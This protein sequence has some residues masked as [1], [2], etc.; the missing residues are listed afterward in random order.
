MNLRQLVFSVSV[1]ASALFA[2]SVAT[3]QDF[4]T[5]KGNN[6][7]TGKRNDP[8]P[9]VA[10]PGEYFYGGKGLLTWFQPN[11]TTGRVVNTVVDDNGYRRYGN[12][13]ITNS[14]ATTF[15]SGWLLP[16]ILQE[17]T[18]SFLFNSSAA[19]SAY[20]YTL[21]VP[22][23]L[24]N[25]TV[26][27]SGTL[28]TF[29]WSIKPPT[30]NTGL[31]QVSVWLPQGPTR[32]GTGDVFQTRYYVYKIESAGGQVDYDVVDTT[33]GGGGWVRLGNGG[34]TSDKLFPYDGTNPIKVTLYNT[35]P[36]DSLGNLL[37]PDTTRAV[38]ADAARAVNEQG[39]YL[40]QP[41][42]GTVGA[43]T[44]VFAP[45]TVRS[46]A[47]V[48]GAFQTVETGRLTAYKY[49]DG[50][51]IWSLQTAGSDAGTTLDNQSADVVAQYPFVSTTTN[52]KYFGYDYF[53]AAITNDA[54][55][56]SVVNYQPA[57]EDGDYD[58]YAYLPGDGGGENYGTAVRYTIYEGAT[59]TNLTINQSTGTGW[60]R[61]GTRKFHHSN[62]VGSELIV[63][64]SNYSA[65]AGDAGKLSYADAIYFAGTNSGAIKSTP[66]FTKAYIKPDAVSAPVEKEV[67]IVATAD[68]RLVCADA[69]GRGDGTTQIY[70]TYP[71]TPDPTNSTW[72]D[73][74]QVNGEDGAGGIAEM[75][76]GFDTT[77]A[78]VQRFTISGNPT[79]Y[80]YIGSNNGRVY[81]VDMT[82]RGDFDSVAR[83]PGTTKRVWSYTSDYPVQPAQTGT[84]GAIRGSVAYFETTD[85]PTLYVPS[86]T[87]RLYALDALGNP[88]NKTT[89]VRW[90]YPAF[91]A[92]PLAPISCTPAIE[93]G[94][95]YFGTQAANGASKFLA[96]D[97][98]TGT[99]TWS[100]NGADSY[101]GGPAT[102]RASYLG[103]VNP[104]S[105][106]IA[107]SSGRVESRN[108]AT[109]ALTWATTELP[110]GTI[111]P[112]TFTMMSLYDASGVY[113][114]SAQPAIMVAQKSGAMT[115]LFA[116]VSTTNRFGARRAWE[117]TA[118]GGMASG[119]SQWSTGS[120]AF[121]Y[122][123]A[124]DQN[125]F[126]YAFG[127]TS[128]GGGFG[129]PPGDQTAVEN[130]TQFDGV[131][132]DI[133]VKLVNKTT[134]DA[135]K[136]GSL[137]Y[138]ALDTTPAV[139]AGFEWGQTLYAVCYRFKGLDNSSPTP[140]HPN[141]GFQVSVGGQAL[142]RI[143][144]EGQTFASTDSSVPLDA[145]TSDRLDG[146]AAFAIIIQGAG[147][148]A[149]P[150]GSGSLRIDLQAVLTS[151]SSAQTIAQDPAKSTIVF[152]V[153][154]PLALVMT[155][156]A[157]SIGFNTNAT[158]AE[159]VV[160]GSPNIGGVDY[161]RLART[162]G[163]IGHGKTGD[164]T[165]QV[166]DRSLMTL[167]LGPGR[168]LPNIR[169]QRRDLGWQGGSAAVYK[170]LPG[171]A[172]Q[173]EDLPVNIPNNSLDY[174]D[175]KRNGVR[176][177]KDI[178]GN[179]EN[180]LFNGVTLNPPTGV[181]PATPTTRTLVETPFT[182]Q[183]DVPRY[184]PSNLSVW[185]DAFGN[186]LAGG[187]LGNMIVFYDTNGSGVID[188][189]SVTAYRSFN[190]A[191]QVS[192][193]E[194]FSLKTPIVD[195]GSL[196]SGTG[197]APANP[198]SDTS[199]GFNPWT[200]LYMNLF[201][202]FTV[203]NEGNVNLLRL[204][205]AKGFRVS[206]GSTARTYP[207]AIRS[208]ANDS[209][210]WLDGLFHL[211]SDIDSRMYTAP[212][213]PGFAQVIL[214]KPRVG[215]RSGTQL[216]A[217]PRRRANGNLGVSSS[218][219][220]A[221]GPAPSA[222]KVAITVP[223]GFPVGTYVV[224]L[225]VVE[226]GSGLESDTIDYTGTPNDL[227]QP[228]TLQEGISTNTFRLKF[229][230]TETRLTNTHSSGAATMIEEL[231][232]TPN[233]AYT[234]V[235][236]NPTGARDGSG[237]MAVVYASD[238]DNRDLGLPAPAVLDPTKPASSL[239]VVSL[240]GS[241][242]S[243]ATGFN[244][245]RDLN[246]LLPQPTKWFQTVSGP[247]PAQ[248][249]LN[250]LFSIGSGESLISSAFR[251]PSLP[252][253]GM[254][255]SLTGAAKETV[256]MAFV[257]DAVKS[258]S[259]GN[260][261]VSRIMVAPLSMTSASGAVSIGTPVALPFDE[262]RKGRI[263]VLQLDTKALIVYSELVGNA[264][265]IS[266]T[267]FDGT[268]FT[269][270]VKL[271]WIKG[272]ES[273]TSPSLSY[274]RDP[275][276]GSACF[277]SFSGKMSGASTTE[278]YRAAITVDNTGQP[279]LNAPIMGT[280]RTEFIKPSSS[281]FYRLRGVQNTITD[282]GIS[283]AGGVVQSL[284]DGSVTF[285]QGR[286]TLRSSMGGNIQVDTD[287][288]TIR[289]SQ[290]LPTGRSK[291]VVTY[292]AGIERD[293]IVE[294]A[295]YS[296]SSAVLDYHE[297]GADAGGFL[298]YWGDSNGQRVAINTG[299]R[300]AR[301]VETY[302]RASGGPGQPARPFVKTFRQGVDLPFLPA[303]N[304]DGSLVNFNVS[305]PS[306]GVYYFQIDPIKGKLF[307][308]NP[309]GK[310]TFTYTYLDA[311]GVQ[312]L[313]STPVGGVDAS[314]IVEMEESPVPM[315]AAQ[316][317]STLSVFADPMRET[318]FQRP[319]MYWMLWH[320]LRNGSPDIYMQSFSPNFTAR[321]RK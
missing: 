169:V 94:N 257:G 138:N 246:G 284:V 50:T 4:G 264:S 23:A 174:P 132:R 288:G 40:A 133:K 305:P 140:L 47:I 6:A 210:T 218:A 159:N 158:S 134:Y 302:R 13:V 320:S 196:P 108:A 287:L 127:P 228:L 82:G 252:Q 3:A 41:V 116:D 251:S 84:L 53:S 74:N 313:Y 131:Y 62:A 269:V 143:S 45:L 49:S 34:R 237:N 42:V 102:V 76:S 29:Q 93:F 89:T 2:T 209:M 144:I 75:P 226:E 222:P 145:T 201:Q 92:Q 189:N 277:L 217:N 77:S 20:R 18:N 172:T 205:L 265:S 241:S 199:Y 236:Q 248:T 81:C 30:G 125:G 309:T 52:P 219:L 96:L 55:L 142:R 66:V 308:N 59:A 240:P 38:Y 293:S 259:R 256:Y 21:V 126:L 254:V 214:Q 191:G 242:I 301:L 300:T 1:A 113:G 233:P 70:W 88:A 54:S 83:K 152:S 272:F 90:T 168:G 128:A 225:R 71:S 86:R 56:S 186:T 245:L 316:N 290:P 156:S 216:L 67:V 299:L 270:P 180:P 100:I 208:D 292:A 28:Q 229:N 43:N 243:S 107:D 318:G 163:T 204:R 33:L 235:N 267:I 282:I 157:N 224:D 110:S 258:T 68:G 291:I 234:N 319:P 78:L 27:L 148:V 25:N 178:N 280:S 44:Y 130:N 247:F 192:V 35:I 271:G 111:A 162:F 238:K 187:Y 65:V 105:V 147:A 160:N 167:V 185:G 104:D 303:L 231:L 244:W 103:G 170:P 181:N 197:F 230:V 232:G 69:A 211:W 165:I 151:G 9:P 294:G 22:S 220:N 263:S 175:I 321:P 249:S 279:D 312:Q 63:S 146:Y 91:T 195:L 206:D 177:T 120:P 268:N 188:E 61:L 32:L 58:L 164:A 60:V 182:F 115:A 179:A 278:V 304:A 221:S 176:V 200:G 57:I 11:A 109:G 274:Y 123:F 198:W 51:P 166:V 239:Y 296:G 112:L 255:D 46:T 184:Q 262:G 137:T 124:G 26:N 114:A 95:V 275:A 183:V 306:S 141:A 121:G 194:R 118:D 273:V 215:D 8:T 85:G 266:Y 119:M 19:S 190:L 203:V 80:L 261:E 212:G 154:N 297:E 87:G 99:V 285:G 98:R 250:S 173:M 298:P 122:M 283:T 281:G 202:P 14:A 139:P 314:W 150:P 72:T 161:T 79:D 24:G 295:S 16:T 317:E 136:T 193:D 73:P 149:I 7:R 213:G 276:N 315:D 207:A 227:T 15:T 31:Y 48:N 310:V 135:L 37:D 253:A 171:F 311:N 155:T 153:A 286:Y 36:R 307:V 260:V 117:Y 223:L 39:A 12:G 106:F 101:L 129:D 5:S 289:F 97:A 17:A 64:V 10:N